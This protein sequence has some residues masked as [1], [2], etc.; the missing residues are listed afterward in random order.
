MR[1]TRSWAPL[2]STVLAA[3]LLAACGGGGADTT[4]KA[5]ITSVKV[6]GDSLADSGTFGLKFTVNGANSKVYPEIVAQ[7]YG[8]APLCSVY[9]FTGTTFV[10]NPTQTAAPIR[11]SAAGASTTTARPRRRCRSCSS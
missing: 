4:P 11:R 7:S 10:P 2:A 1:D 8:L 6:M 5:A 3:L 9:T